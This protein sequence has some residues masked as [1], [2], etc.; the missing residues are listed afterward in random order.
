M[1]CIVCRKEFEIF[2]EGKG[3]HNQVKSKRRRN[4]ITCSSKCSKIYVRIFSYIYNKLKR[5]GRIK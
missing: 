5:D 2:E 4:S 3:S 1:K